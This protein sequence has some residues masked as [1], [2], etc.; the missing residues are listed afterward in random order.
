MGMAAVVT[1]TATI[2][3]RFDNRAPSNI[4]NDVVLNPCV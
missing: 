3:D 4:A 1:G 2:D